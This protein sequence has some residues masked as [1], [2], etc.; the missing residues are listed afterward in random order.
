MNG[1]ASG[2][3]DRE[4]RSLTESPNLKSEICIPENKKV[5]VNSLLKDDDNEDKTKM[6]A[7]TIILILMIITKFINRG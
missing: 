5:S 2:A 6:G 7:K 1:N 3:Q 4:Q